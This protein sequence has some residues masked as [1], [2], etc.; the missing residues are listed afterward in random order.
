MLQSKFRWFQER[1][2]GGLSTIGPAAARANDEVL[3]F[4][5]NEKGEF[6]RQAAYCLGRM[7]PEIDDGKFSI[8]DE[9]KESFNN[10]RRDGR[11]A[12]KK[13]QPQPIQEKVAPSP[14]ETKSSAQNSV[15]VEVFGV[16]RQRIKGARAVYSQRGSG[17]PLSKRILIEAES[18][19]LGVFYLEHVPPG[20]GSLTVHAQGYEP[21]MIG[22]SGSLRIRTLEVELKEAPREQVKILDEA[23]KPVP[24]ATV[25]V[26]E[27]RSTPLAPVKLITDED[28]IF[29]FSVGDGFVSGTIVKDG[30]MQ[31]RFVLDSKSKDKVIILHPPFRITG[32]VVDANSGE[33]I[34]RFEIKLGYLI[35]GRAEFFDD[36]DSAQS[37][38]NFTD[39]AYEIKFTESFDKVPSFLDQ[40][41]LG[42]DAANYDR[43]V[44]RQFDDGEGDIEMNMELK[45]K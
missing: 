12:A 38:G 18:D 13:V 1:A 39:G 24:G 40:R 45:K 22:M 7:N 14:P 36:H 3:Q 41:V 6:R 44:S 25:V 34:P 27:Y 32:S 19:D 23:K 30:F 31:H 8:P 17:D 4:L 26:N 5:M 10:G 15:R 20:E 33:K 42:V 11:E 37:L 9:F 35:G 43:A 21:S 28:G 2:I 29:G 16:N